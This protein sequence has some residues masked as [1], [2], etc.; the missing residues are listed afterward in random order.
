MAVA[1]LVPFVVADQFGLQRDIYLVIYVAAVV[2]L[3]AGWALDTGQSPR[4][5]V[6]RRWGLAA[7]ARHRLRR[8]RRVVASDMFLPPHRE[9]RRW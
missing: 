5:M 2:G 9:E 8:R 7:V 3:F 4:E 1:F 6:T